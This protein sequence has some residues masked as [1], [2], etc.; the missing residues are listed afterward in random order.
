MKEPGAG[1]QFIFGVHTALEIL[2][3]AS[4]KVHRLYLRRK[5][6]D[7]RTEKLISL[8]RARGIEVRAVADD[9][10]ERLAGGGNHQGVILEAEAPPVLRL[11]DVLPKEGEAAKSEVWLGLDELTDPHN[12]GAI[13]RSAACFGASTV[14]LPERR[15]VQL[16]PTVQKAASGALEKVKIVSIVN[17]NQAVLA[18]KERGF[19]V[20]G[21]ALEGKPLGQVSFS[22]PVLLLIGSEGEG[23]R[24]K[25]KEHCDELVRIPQSEGGV[26]S[27][28]ASCACAVLLYEIARQTASKG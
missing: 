14:L 17:L 15:S 23:L 25:T 16:T 8:A 10:L 21:A 20:Y 28:N 19:W 6:G 9:V 7:P 4:R 22:G 2:Q 5:S 13:L 11:E 24:Q 12:L 18:L 1:V 26:E 27:L 3:G